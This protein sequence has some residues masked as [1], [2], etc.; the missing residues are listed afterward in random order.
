MGT[1]FLMPSV[2]LPVCVVYIAA[3]PHGDMRDIA[4]AQHHWSTV[5]VLNSKGSRKAFIVRVKQNKVGFLVYNDG[6]PAAFAVEQK[7]TANLHRGRG[8]VEVFPFQP[9]PLLTAVTD[10]TVPDHMQHILRLDLK[11]GSQ[12]C[13]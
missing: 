8:L 13:F 1:V 3:R 12:W 10:C 5:L 9:T 11:H 4:G 7:D 2:L 6:L